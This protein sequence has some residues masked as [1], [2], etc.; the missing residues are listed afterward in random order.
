[1]SAYT[2]T[3]VFQSIVEYAFPIHEI[4]DLCAYMWSPQEKTE[5]LVS[6]CEQY[7]ISVF[8]CGCV[9]S[10]SKCMFV[11]ASTPSTRTSSR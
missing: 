2:H 5:S 9:S 3:E 7:A 4:L 8:E 11:L 6:R 1:M 10:R